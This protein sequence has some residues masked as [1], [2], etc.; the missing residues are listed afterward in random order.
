M[1]IKLLDCTLRDGAHINA[2]EFSNDAAVGIANA[3]VDA[4]IELIELGF[5]EP[6]GKAS[7]ESVYFDSLS[8]AEEYYRDIKREGSKFGLM[9]RTDRCPLEILDKSDIFD[10]FR[11]AFYPEHLDQVAE[12]VSVLRDLGY[13]VYLNPIAVTHYT[14]D[15]F[16]S[17]LTRISAMDIAG[18][19]IVDTYG[20]L[21]LAKLEAYGMAIK[22]VMDDD[23]EIGIHLHQNLNSSL[24][25][26]DAFSRQGHKSVIYDSSILG[27]GRMPG[28]FE[29]EMVANYLNVAND[30]DK[31]YDIDKILQAGCL[32]VEQYRK[33]RNW[34]YSAIYAKS[35]ILNID[36][37]YPEYFEDTGLSIV[38]NLIA[39]QYVAD[40]AR[41]RRFSKEDA[42]RAVSYTLDE[43]NT[44]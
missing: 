13:N 24:S 44:L 27:M 30:S 4:S 40:N 15:E 33:I 3:L 1:K 23:I 19:S 6:N 41:N 29:T 9:L 25:L 18:V 17:I 36:R 22:E 8:E 38:K 34:G 28:N 39:Q 35:A 43:R 42:E 16:R 20:A 26:A 2:G 21:S 7:R 32:F 31:K 11:I 12:Y 5:L 37:T 10:F 14:S